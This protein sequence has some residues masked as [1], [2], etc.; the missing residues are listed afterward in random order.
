MI[1]DLVGTVIPAFRSTQSIVNNVIGSAI[2]VIMW[3]YILYIGVLDP[4][5]GINTLWPLFGISNQ[6]LAAIALCLGTVVLIKMKR[7]RFALFTAIP[8]VWLLI[9][10]LTAGY[11]KLFDESPT[12][13]FLAHAKKYSDAREAGTI[14]P[15]AKIHVY[16]YWNRFLWNPRGE[17]G[18]GEP[19]IYG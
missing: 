2:A 1:Q 12:I 9:C 8:A 5:G 15:P 19:Q 10:T 6:M 11:Q 4:L 16:R 17:E 3:G 14:L 7:E 18:P 13:S